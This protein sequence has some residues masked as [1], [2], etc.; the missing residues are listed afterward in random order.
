L[1]VAA[2]FDLDGT[3]ADTA[4][5]LGYALNSLLQRYGRPRVPAE[6]TRP[7]ASHGARGLLE[8]GFGIRPSEPYYETLRDEFLDLY[9]KN[10]CRETQLFPGV[11]TLL[12][13]LAERKMPW[14]IVTNKLQRF[15]DPLV[16]QLGLTPRA[17]CVVSGD[18]FA[19]PKPYPD[20]LLGAATLMAIPATG[21]VYV[22]DDL[23]DM[24][25]GLAAGMQVVAARYGYLGAGTDP[26][27]WQAHAVIDEPTEL[28]SYLDSKA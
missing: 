3:L 12:D 27:Q 26:A 13:R 16:R 1:I 10:L 14:G 25:A 8:I 15:T 7:R 9:E 18:T 11:S 24:Q 20:P 6:L 23:R 28:L 4:P 19:R 21:A 2:L 22:G 17:A 5:D